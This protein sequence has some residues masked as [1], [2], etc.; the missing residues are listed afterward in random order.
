MA[1]FT[2]ASFLFASALAIALASTSCA[3]RRV[4]AHLSAAGSGI[5]RDFAERLGLAIDAPL[6]DGNRIEELINGDG[7]FPPM[8]EAIRSATN[9]VT[10]ENFIWRSGSLSDFFITAMIER[11]RAGVDV[12]VVVDAFGTLEL[13]NRDEERLREAGV[14]F[15]KHSPLWK[16]WSWNHRTH[17]KLMIVDGRIGFIGGACIGDHW[18]GNAEHEPLW[19][20]TH[21]QVE[22][23]V[24]AELQR[25]F[26]ANWKLMNDE[27]LPRNFYPPL[28]PAGRSAAQCFSSGPHEG[29]QRARFT[30]LES[31]HA[32]K[33]NIRIAHSYFVPDAPSI[34]ALV[35]ARRRG[36]RV[37]IMTP[38]RIHAN[39]VRRASRS[40][41]RKLLEAGVEFYE[42]QPTAF[43]CKTLIV[44]DVWMSV[45]SVNF[46]ERSFDIND[47]A[48]LNVL[49]GA[50]AAQQVR[51]FEED[52]RKSIRIM[53]ESYKRRSLWIKFVENFY[54][55][56][57]GVL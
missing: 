29:A 3:T 1:R 49:D 5:T 18:L 6:R 17:R 24:V 12:R 16:I 57:R 28:Q 39:V 45:G 8:L 56:F 26:E 13:S 40:R 54:G 38:G 10:F 23:P 51:V 11:A 22:G 20:D 41:W 4:P 15:C 32:A 47:E 7:I 19:R 25:A 55:M 27:A 30:F 43:H 46:D 34:R 53:L 42:F 2:K 48:N 37:E 36:V 35:E 50:F 33:K 44:D 52:K 14:R 31:I 21:Y 9:S